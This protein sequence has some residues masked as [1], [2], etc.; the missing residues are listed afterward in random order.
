MRVDVEGESL[1]LLP[2]A[3]VY[4]PNR[5][6]LLL[7]D[8]H[9]GKAETFQRH[10]IPIP[11]ET[12]VADINRLEGLIALHRPQEVAILGDLV[13]DVDA[14]GT[15]GAKA[16]TKLRSATPGIGFTL[17]RG[18]HDRHVV[19]LPSTWEIEEVSTLVVGPF[20]LRHE[21]APDDTHYVLAGHLHP[22]VELRASGDLLHLACFH[23]GPRVAVLPAFTPFSSGVRMSA[24]A[25]EVFA[26]VD[27][28]VVATK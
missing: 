3:A 25:G 13:H 8:V 5:R 14:L 11:S 17:V 9:L 6:M 26:I 4:W 2:D 15:P 1:Q 20:L 12:A 22:T 21:P 7:A 24:H 19:E 18:N 16:L 27:G 23:F 10:G 28:R